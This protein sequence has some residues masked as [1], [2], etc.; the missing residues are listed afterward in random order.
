[1]VIHKD[2]NIVGLGYCGMRDEWFGTL[3]MNVDARSTEG[4]VG[5]VTVMNARL[6]GTRDTKTVVSHIRRLFGGFKLYGSG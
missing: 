2:S 6:T 3:P 4:G 1:M 5:E